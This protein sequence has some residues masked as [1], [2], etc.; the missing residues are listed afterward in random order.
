MQHAPE[1]LWQR[2]IKQQASNV[3]YFYD[4]FRNSP[5]TT[6]AAGWIFELRIH[7]LFRQG[8][9]I[10]LFPVIGRRAGANFVCNGYAASKEKKDQ[11]DP[12]LSNQKIIPR[13]KGESSHLDSTTVLR[14]IDSLF[15]GCSPF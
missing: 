1:M 5:G 14:S 11:K 15:I 7:E 12:W 6:S 8:N 10:G 9:T 3:R 4:L 2:H 13:M